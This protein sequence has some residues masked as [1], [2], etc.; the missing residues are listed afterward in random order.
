MATIEQVLSRT[1]ASDMQEANLYIRRLERLLNEAGNERDR[2]RAEN[3]RLHTEAENSAAMAL[4]AQNEV[5]R[6]RAALEIARSGLLRIEQGAES[7]RASIT[8][9]LEQGAPQAFIEAKKERDDGW[10][11]ER[12]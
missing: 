10:P 1:D 7:T 11:D 4:E 9:A 8:R 6:L 2:L 3:E 5:E 12:S